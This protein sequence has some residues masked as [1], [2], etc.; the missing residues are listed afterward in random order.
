MHMK[1]ALSAS[2]IKQQKDI[3]MH[4]VFWRVLYAPKENKIFVQ[5]EKAD[6]NLHKYGCSMFCIEE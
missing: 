5:N 3:Q 2:N 6:T 4:P 1:K